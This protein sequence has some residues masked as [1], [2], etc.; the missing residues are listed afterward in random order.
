MKLRCVL[1][2]SL[3]I[4][5]MASVASAEY[6]V[7]MS[8]AYAG[9]FDASGTQLADVPFVATPKADGTVDYKAQWDPSYLGEV[10]AFNVVANVSGLAADQD[11]LSLQWSATVA[12]GMINDDG[13]VF[14]GAYLGNPVANIDPP[15]MGGA[16]KSNAPSAAPFFLNL[17]NGLNIAFDMQT[18]S[19]ETGNGNGTYGDYA[20]M[21]QLGEAGGTAAT[22]DANIVGTLYLMA[23][24]P[25]KYEQVFLTNPGYFQIIS[26]NLTGLGISTNRSMPA[27]TGKGDGVEFAIPEPSTIALLGCGLFGLLAYAWRKRK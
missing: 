9:S 14:G 17:N 26:G 12:G 5:G 23:T 2:V 20:A 10:H 13:G 15:L 7:N 11:W 4:L 18:G 27:Y 21:Y 3:A 19:T 16:T 8:L 6:V 25:G 1:F 22:R 24:G